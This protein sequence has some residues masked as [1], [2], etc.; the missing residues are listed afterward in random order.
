M[1]VTLVEKS[2]SL[3]SLFLLKVKLA[4]GVEYMP[5]LLVMIETTLRP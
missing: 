2:H 1:Q 5:M 3:F 4:E